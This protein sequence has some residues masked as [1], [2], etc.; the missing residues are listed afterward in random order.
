MELVP[1]VWV[2]G[3]VYEL[4]FFFVVDKVCSKHN[5]GNVEVFREFVDI[6]GYQ[7]GFHQAVRR[8]GVGNFYTEDHSQQKAY[9]ILYEFSGFS[10]A[11]YSAANRLLHHTGPSGSKM[12]RIRQGSSDR[13]NQSGKYN[14]LSAGWHN[15]IHKVL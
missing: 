2:E 4:Y 13:L 15:D 10:V 9:N 14:R 3:D 6:F 7:A 5:V 11:T 8:I 1:P 12:A